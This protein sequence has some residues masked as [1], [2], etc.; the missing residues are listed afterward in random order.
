MCLSSTLKLF[1]SYFTLIS[2]HHYNK[3]L[4]VQSVD[5]QTHMIL[6]AVRNPV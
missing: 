2:H 6:R 4:V 1:S 3:L 5:P